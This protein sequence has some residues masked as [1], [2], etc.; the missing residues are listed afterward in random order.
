[1]DGMNGGANG[2]PMSGYTATELPL[3]LGMGL[4]M[5]ERAM[6]GYANMTEAEKE[7]V[8]FAAKDARTKEE[9]ERIIS[10]LEPGESGGLKSPE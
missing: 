5:N 10:S 6:N 9:M 3:G 4:A 1:M 7:R 2:G 8:I